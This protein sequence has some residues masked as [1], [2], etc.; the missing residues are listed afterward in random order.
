MDK[1]KEVDYRKEKRKSRI[2]W[3]I[4]IF[5]ACIWLVVTLVPFVFMVMNSFRKQFDMLSQ[6]V[7]HLPDPWYFQNY[8]EVM[9]HGFF[10]YFFRSVFV[11][12]V[13]LVLMLMI[14]AFAAYPLSRMKF[15]L[16]GITYAGIVAMMSVP[17]HVTL[18]PIFKMTTNMGL[19]DSLQALIGPYVTFALPMSVFILTAFMTTI[20]KEIEESAEI[21][22]CN[23][24]R[25][26]FSI[27]LP[28]SKSGLSTLAIYNGVSMWN[29]FAFAN[30]LLQTASNKTLPLALGQFKGEHS[31]DIPIILSVLV[32]SVLP[33][34]VLFIIF[35]DK[36][37]KGMMAGAVKG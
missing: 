6:G 25:N 13:S 37:V 19:Y 12:A 1:Q 27:I 3:G 2:A 35:Q 8:A 36:L 4:A 29:E 30:T 32:L 26:F 18:I 20:P 14:S 17:M 15:R 34:I 16:R 5:F 23:K 31:L 9:T 7:F 21:D 22:G 28:L 11:V 24:F 10:G 33:M